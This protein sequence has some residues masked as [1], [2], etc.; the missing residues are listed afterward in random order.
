[1][2]VGA[3]IGAIGS[4]LAVASLPASSPQAARAIARAITGARAMRRSDV[5]GLPVGWKDTDGS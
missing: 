3:A 4:E 5:M 2:P 1:M